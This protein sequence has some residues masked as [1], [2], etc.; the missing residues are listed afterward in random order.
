MASLAIN[1]AALKALQCFSQIRSLRPQ[2]VG[3][4]FPFG[5]WETLGAMISGLQPVLKI[6]GDLKLS[7]LVGSHRRQ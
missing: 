1:S 4:A 6:K 5:R 3:W 7:G 2:S